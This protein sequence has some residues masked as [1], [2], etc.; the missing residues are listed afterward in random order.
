MEAFL[1]FSSDNLWFEIWPEMTLVL[2]AVLI[3][4]LDLFSSKEK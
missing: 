1:K 3:L 2:G 4:L